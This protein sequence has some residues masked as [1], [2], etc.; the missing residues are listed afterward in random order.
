MRERM[1]YLIEL[2]RGAHWIEMRVH[3]CWFKNDTKK[4]EAIEWL[5]HDDE[6]KIEIEEFDEEHN[7]IRLE[8][9]QRD[10]C[11]ACMNNNGVSL[12][13][14]MTYCKVKCERVSADDDACDK[15]ESYNQA[16]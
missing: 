9:L 16:T 6:V 5:Q 1:K 14:F 8:V 2:A 3:K 4:M 10:T 12:V 7:T 13:D 15:F 11:G